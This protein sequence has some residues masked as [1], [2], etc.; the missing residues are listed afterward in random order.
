MPISQLWNQ[1]TARFRTPR[2]KSPAEARSAS[3]EHRR[4]RSPTREP[5][6]TGPVSPGTPVDVDHW[7]QQNRDPS[8][9]SS[10]PST[11]SSRGGLWGS[12]NAGR[13]SSASDTLSDTS[14]A[15]PSPN[16]KPP[17]SQRRPTSTAS[18]LSPFPPRGPFSDLLRRGPSNV[19]LG[20]RRAI[21]PDP[22]QERTLKRERL[23]GTPE[24][25]E[26]RRP[27]SDA[28]AQQRSG[29]S[30]PLTPDSQCSVPMDFGSEPELGDARTPS[31]H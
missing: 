11:S 13:C 4:T 5:R 25:Q 26:P 21:D 28:S 17:V 8:T 12:E 1:L 3:P 7:L 24:A 6:S 23:V 19:A 22:V 29:S 15:A 31:E 20:K 14:R 18:L 2:R 9:S 16:P 10:I 27:C 30:Q